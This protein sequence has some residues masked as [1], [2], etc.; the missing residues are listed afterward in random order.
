MSFL[1]VILLVGFGI[2]YFQK[3][4]KAKRKADLLRKYGDANIVEKILSKRIWVGQTKNELLDALG[5]PFDVDSKLMK[6]R[7][8]EIWKYNPNGKN[9]FGLRITLDDGRV[10]AWDSKV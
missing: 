5:H 2:F 8:R 6:T 7:S 3:E 9:R 1:I 10:A 4:K